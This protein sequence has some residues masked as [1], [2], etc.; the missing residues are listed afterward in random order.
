MSLCFSPSCVEVEDIED[1]CRQ[2][3]PSFYLD[4]DGSSYVNAFV[5]RVPRSDVGKR[6]GWS[7]F[8]VYVSSRDWLNS[9]KIRY[10]GLADAEFISAFPVR[11]PR[12]F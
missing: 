10:L 3:V 9:D 7:Y 1:M 6:F 12:N 5:F 8:A 4:I 2:K 11:F